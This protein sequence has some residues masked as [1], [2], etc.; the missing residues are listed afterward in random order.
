[1]DGKAELG[2]G[3]KPELTGKGLGI[4][5][6]N[7]VLENITFLNGVND[8]TLSVALFN[9]RAIKAYEAVG[10]TR[11]NTFIHNTNG[12]NYLFLRMDKIQNQQK[13]ITFYQNTQSCARP[14]TRN[15]FASDTN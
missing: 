6:I 13:G 4:N 14:T 9:K 7:A 12:C 1:M 10:F 5:F 2:L 11:K 3:L 15:Q 8:F